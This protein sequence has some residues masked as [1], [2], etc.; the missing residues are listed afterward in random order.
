MV[1][2]RHEGARRGVAQQG[3]RPVQHEQV[4]LSLVDI[5]E[6]LLLHVPPERRPQVELLVRLAKEKPHQLAKVKEQAMIIAGPEAFRAAVTAVVSAQ[7]KSHASAAP[8]AAPRSA[9]PRS[10]PPLPPLGG[11]SS[12]VEPPMP[13]NLQ[14]IFGSLQSPE[15]FKA[16][17]LHAFHCRTPSCPVPE[18]ANLTTKLERLHQHISSCTA[19]PEESCLLCRVWTYLKFFR[20]MSSMGGIGQSSHSAA[21]G[22]MSFSSEL[23]QSSQLVPRWVDGRVAWVPA[24]DA[25]AQ[26]QA[27][28]DS[29]GAAEHPGGAADDDVLDLYA[30]RHHKRPRHALEGAAE[31]NGPEGGALL[32]LQQGVLHNEPTVQSSLPMPRVL[33]SQSA[34]PVAAPPT[35]PS[36]SAGLPPSRFDFEMG[37]AGW[38]GWDGSGGGWDSGGGG[39]GSMQAMSGSKRCGGVGEAGAACKGGGCACGMLGMMA[40]ISMASL[41]SQPSNPLTLS[42]NLQDMMRRCSSMG[43]LGMQLGLSS[44][45][46]GRT[47]GLSSGDLATQL[48]EID[49]TAPAGLSLSRSKSHLRDTNVSELSLSA[50]LNEAELTTGGA[51]AN[52]L[53][54]SFNSDSSLDGQKGHAVNPELQSIMSDFSPNA[55]E[56]GR[57]ALVEPPLS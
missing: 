11:V 2:T 1:S 5:V 39:G 57:A 31:T 16:S 54:D 22:A 44:S 20:E 6:E 18:C 25:L 15:E 53:D 27:Q 35:Y 34:A 26:V 49:S 47:L 9:L 30:H 50:F 45:D 13:A 7:T 33:P 41:R 23:S 40:P 46:L 28:L 19:G 12:F 42:G 24:Q 14:A 38:G 8:A 36:R 29:N 3:A 32:G 17:L 43:D 56:T 55:I 52:P 4:S 21:A 10:M 37:T 51:R 48:A